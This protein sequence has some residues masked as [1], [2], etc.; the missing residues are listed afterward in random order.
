[1]QRIV[2]NPVA[3]SSYRTAK[4]H[5]FLASGL[6]AGATLRRALPGASIK[7][8]EARDRLGGRIHSS[9]LPLDVSA[10]EQSSSAPAALSKTEATCSVDLGAAYVHGCNITNSVWRLAEVTGRGLDMQAGGYSNGWGDECIW[11][12]ADGRVIDKRSLKR[13]FKVGSRGCIRFSGVVFL[14]VIASVVPSAFCVGS[15]RPR[16]LR[17]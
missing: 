5:T 9:M 17:L 7:V 3:T 15:K 14:G 11:R 1:M 13:A 10:H 12:T 8:I 16:V 4:T 2:R 6:S